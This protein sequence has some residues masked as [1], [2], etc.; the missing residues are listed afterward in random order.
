MSDDGFEKQL[1]GIIANKL[2]GKLLSCEQLS[3]G[4]SQETYC[5]SVELN[6]GA[7]KFALRRAPAGRDQNEN[8][9]R[10]GISG[11]ISLIRAAHSAR[12]PV[13]EIILD[14]NPEDGL[15]EGFIMRWLDGDTLGSRI[16]RA[17]HLAKIR[18]ELAYQCGQALARIHNIDVHATQ[19]DTFLQR[20]SPEESVNTMWETYKALSTP[21]PMI[22]YTARWLLQNL[23]DDSRTA[24]VHS[25]FRNGN[26][27][28]DTQ[29]VSAVLD[30]ELAHIGDPMRDLGWIC[31]NSWRFGNTALAVG[32]FGERQDLY[33]GYED[34]CGI[35]IDD[36]HVKFWE[37]FGSFWWAI[38]CLGMADQY[39]NAAEKSVE[40]PGI[41][42]RTSECQVDCVNLLIPGP[43]I[44]EQPG[45]QGFNS[46]MPRVDELVSSV[47]EF[48]RDTVMQETE[49]RTN[50]MARVAANSLDIVQRDLNYGPHSRAAEKMRLLQLPGTSND[51][52]AELDM[53]R[54]QL[55]E[56]IRN[57]ETGLDDPALITHLRTTVANQLAIDQPRYSGLQTALSGGQKT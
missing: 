44:L 35:Q 47:G 57:E 31:T 2:E 46:E 39:R 16:V 32:G 52:D 37:V 36:L 9:E 12:V 50:F 27:M 20:V 13:P 30:W 41:A 3:G 19:L 4:A 22:D 53:L 42:R 56:L 55:V 1:A 48:L 33:R 38:A 5:L 21:Q 40:R 17:D 49:G 18:P 11:E 26:L 45:N 28:I 54:W 25:D 43:V 6:E 8:N 7:T 14:L 34:E 10:P 24:L 15:G 23:P 29:G 51:T